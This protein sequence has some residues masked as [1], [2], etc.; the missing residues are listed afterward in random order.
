MVWI[1][2]RFVFQ[3]T[4]ASENTRGRD[5]RILR[6][7]MGGDDMG[8]KKDL[9]KEIEKAR[10]FLVAIVVVSV[11]YYVVFLGLILKQD[12][13]QS[14]NLEL[15]N[16]ALITGGIMLIFP[17]TKE[18]A[19]YRIVIKEDRWTVYNT[20][21]EEKINFT[22]TKFWELLR[23]QGSGIKVYNQTSPLYYWIEKLDTSKEEAVIWV[24]LSA[25][26]TVLIV[27]YGFPEMDD[28]FNDP[29]RVFVAFGGNKR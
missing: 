19:V 22:N 2:D 10:R 16:E 5:V 7:V 21:G 4:S 11:F 27:Q 17:E 25:N 29:Y 23:K 18:D 28:I 24:N 13:K 26:S 20:L 14:E 3:H 1:E 12:R 8:D 6:F 9:L 15:N